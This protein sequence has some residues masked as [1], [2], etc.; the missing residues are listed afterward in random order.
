[1]F[2]LVAKCQHAHKPACVTI[3]LRSRHRLS[4]RPTRLV[5]AKPTS[6]D[7][8]LGDI[9]W[10][11]SLGGES[12]PTMSYGLLP[13]LKKY[14]SPFETDREVLSSVLCTLAA[15]CFFYHTPGQRPPHI[16]GHCVTTMIQAWVGAPNERAPIR[17]HD[18]V[19]GFVDRCLSKARNLA[20][21]N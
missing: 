15:N 18:A 3:G 4:P 19:V 9:R 13:N 12:L 16:T 11:N 6:I 20:A 10:I 2:L 1:M 7:G 5:R 17:S 21:S 14:I 8:G